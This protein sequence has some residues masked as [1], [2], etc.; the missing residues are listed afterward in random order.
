MPRQSIKDYKIKFNYST[1]T[2]RF[3]DIMESSYLRYVQC[4]SDKN[5][6]NFQK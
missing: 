6:D 4:I 3:K 2:T 1:A 5:K